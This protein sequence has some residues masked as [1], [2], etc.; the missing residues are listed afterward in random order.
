M[1]VFH[2]GLIDFKWEFLMGFRDGLE[3]LNV[4]KGSAL[5]KAVTYAMNQ[6]P[7]MK[8]YLHQ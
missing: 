6:R 1:K 4:L 3:S 7:F 5:G 8:N 2:D